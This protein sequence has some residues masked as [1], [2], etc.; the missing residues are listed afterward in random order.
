M[1]FCVMTYGEKKL[2]HIVQRDRSNSWREG[3]GK[4]KEDKDTETG[5]KV[6]GIGSLD[7]G[8]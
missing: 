1:I 5:A 8:D 2:N 3:K 7:Y 4:W 6:K